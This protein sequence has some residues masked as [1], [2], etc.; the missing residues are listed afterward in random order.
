MIKKFILIA[1]LVVLSSGF[2]KKIEFFMDYACFKKDNPGG[3]T[4]TEFYFNIP[5]YSLEYNEEDNKLK[6]SFSI[7]LKIYDN[8]KLIASDRWGQRAGFDKKDDLSSG[9]EIPALTKQY[10]APGTYRLHAVMTDLKSGKTAVIDIPQSSKKFVIPTMSGDFSMSDVQIG[11]KFVKSDDIESEF[12]KNGLVLLPNARKLYGTHKPF[13][14]FYLEVYNVVKNHN[15]SYIWEV[16]NSSGEKV[17]TSGEKVETSGDKELKA[18]GKNIVIRNQVKVHHLKSGA[19][20]FVVKVKD[21]SN[22]D[23]IEKS[24][25]FF[26]FRN[27]D[28]KTKKVIASGNVKDNIAV[29]N[30]KEVNREFRQVL[31]ILSQKKRKIAEQLSDKGKRNFLEQ[32]WSEEEKTKNNARQIF[33]ARAALANS[34]FS[35]TKK[36]GWETARGRV[37]L[38][39][40]EPNTR[41]TYTL[42]KGSYDHEIWKYHKENYEYVFAD[43]HNLGTF[44]LI[45]SDNPDEIQNPQWKDRVTKNKNAAD[46]SEFGF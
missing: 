12:Y 14:P 23:V 43:L 16:M 38:K 32:Y 17:E 29:L 9:K 19:Y 1:I 11:S 41:D 8:G 28:F 46:N 35:N 34:R 20:N 30:N 31:T 18:P 5:A 27:A 33:L 15:Y 45:H 25:R 22:D 24:T 3:K 39:M 7:D 13:M 4:F 26:V 40:G 36:E 2:A 42:L 6:G 10:L 44:R 21:V 37:I